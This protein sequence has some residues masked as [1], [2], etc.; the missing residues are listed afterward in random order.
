VKPKELLAHLEKTFGSWPGGQTK[1][2]P[3]WPEVEQ[4]GQRRLFLIDKPGAAQSVI[5]IGRLG[6]TRLTEDFYALTVLNTILGGS[7]T[8]R[9]NQNL[10]EEHG[11][12]Y[13]AGSQFDFRPQPGPFL[14][15]ASVQTEVT[16]KALSEFIKELRGIM[17][18]IP[19]AELQRAKN[20]VALSYPSSFQTVGQIAGELAELVQY[21]LPDSYFNEYIEKIVKVSQAE[22]QAAARK[23][24]DPERVEIVIVGDRAKVE[25]GLKTLGLGE[26]RL[27]TIE[28]VLGPV[29]RL[30]GQA[31]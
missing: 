6:P 5:R 26:L 19:E 2:P 9:L 28:E 10:R 16:D 30:A 1:A 27:M 15:G 21:N 18:A 29:P 8:S 17:G 22:L 20:Y 13:G 3:L 23:H 11:Y 4:V 7:F 24:L 31:E 12:A 14:A 25:A